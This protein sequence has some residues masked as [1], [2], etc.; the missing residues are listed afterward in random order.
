MTDEK[1]QED[2]PPPTEDI[3]AEVERRQELVLKANEAA[4]RLEK[5]N[6]QMLESLARQEKM[7]VE[8]KLSGVADAGHTPPTEKDKEDAD[9]A[10]LLDGTGYEGTV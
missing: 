1:I 7:I 3:E 8:Q 6:A 9:V 4:E 2:P 5:A 10:R